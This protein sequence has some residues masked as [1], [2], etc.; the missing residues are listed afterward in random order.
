[1]SEEVKERVEEAKEGIKETIKVETEEVKEEVKEGLGFSP[2]ITE[3]DKFDVIVEC[4]K[5][6]SGEIMVKGVD[7]S[8]DKERKDIKQIK[9]TF[10]HASQGDFNVI[11][12]QGGTIINE[13]DA[14][15]HANLNKLEF[16]RF[17]VLIREWSLPE[18][19]SNFNIINLN[20]KIIKSVIFT[21]REKIN[22]EGIL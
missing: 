18:E 11:S 7:A 16:A 22:L 15:D 3:D 4:Y 2:F 6:E 21:L 14:P 5:G 10:K 1:M 17:L 12:S 19:L 20:P 9:F 13:S 8:F